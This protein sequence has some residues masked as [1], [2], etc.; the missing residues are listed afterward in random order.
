MQPSRLSLLIF[1]KLFLFIIWVILRGL[2]TVFFYSMLKG[3]AKSLCNGGEDGSVD[4]ATKPEPFMIIE[5]L[6]LELPFIFQGKT[7]DLVCK[8]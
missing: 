5:G 7:L 8:L 6:I 2:N 3:F 1:S 4:D